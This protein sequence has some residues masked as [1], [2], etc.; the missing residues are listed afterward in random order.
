MTHPNGKQL[1]SARASFRTAARGWSSASTSTTS[2][3]CTSTASASCRS[4]CCC[5]RSASS[6]T[7][8]SSSCSTRTRRSSV[9]RQEGRG[10]RSGRDRGAQDVVDPATGEILLEANDEITRREARDAARR[11]RSQTLHVLRDPEAGRGRR[12]RA[13]R[14]ARTR[15][16]HAGR[17]AQEDLQPAA[18]GRA[19][20]RR[21]RRARSSNRLFFNPQA[22]RPGA[23]RP[24]Q[25]QPEAAARVPAAGR[26]MRKRSGSA[27]RPDHTTLCREDFIVIIKY[28][29]LLRTGG[30][31]PTASRRARTTS[32]TSGNRRVRS[33]GELLANQ[34]TI[35]LARMARI[36]RER[37]SL[38][39]PE[40]ITP[41][42]LVNS[43]TISAVIQSVL[44][45]EPAV[46]VH[47]PDQPAGRADAQ[48][49][50]LGARTRRSDA[51]ARRLRGARRALHALR[52]HVPDRDAGRPEHRPHLVAL[53]LR[54]R[55]RVR[56]PRDA[57]LPGRRAAWS[58]EASRVPGRRRRGP[59]H[60]RAG[61]HAVRQEDGRILE[62][63]R[64]RVRVPRRVPDRRRRTR[65]S[66]WTCRR[67]SWC[68][69]RRR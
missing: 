67:S 35:G 19:A 50:A 9:K 29:L 39:D 11:R 53:D 25:D 24:L 43:R 20:A 44:R 22:L 17:G 55:E 7:A 46:A 21:T 63:R 45:L 16:R 40:Q 32:T 36:I 58:T 57:V 68:R 38:Q 18:A 12:H 5:A 48:A 47:G 26:D 4:P 28:L 30:E 2:C 3:T 62:R 41:Y 61:E 56:L 33:V 49:A 6:P 15:R 69:R 31:V 37:M 65:S 51:R 14:C 59:L 23:R 27:S 13:T 8:R 42:D 64:S 1:C 10:A 60:H 54:A 52:P 66:T 34:F